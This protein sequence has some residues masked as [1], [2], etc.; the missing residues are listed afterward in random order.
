MYLRFDLDNRIAGAKSV[1]AAL[2][3]DNVNGSDMSYPFDELRN[4]NAD[5]AGCQMLA[6][7]NGSPSRSATTSGSSRVFAQ[8]E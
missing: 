5:F 6:R 4:R 8:L 1:S 2:V 3:L 7:R